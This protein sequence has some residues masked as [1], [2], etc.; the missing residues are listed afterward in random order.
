MRKKA[1]FWLGQMDDPRVK[2]FLVE[3]INAPR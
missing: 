2:D 1:I 3:L